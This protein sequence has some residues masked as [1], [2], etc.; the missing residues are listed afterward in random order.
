MSPTQPTI[1]LQVV[2]GLGNRIRAMVSGMALAEGI[3]AKL[4][5]YWFPYHP[6][7]IC[8]FDTIFDKK[9]L[10]SWMSISPMDLALTID[11]LNENDTYNML[12]K[13]D[14]K[15]DL[16]IKSYG[17][18]FRPSVVRWA[19]YLRALKPSPKIR[20]LVK[21]RIQ[22]LINPIGVHIRRGDNKKSIEESPTE[23]FVEVMK[24]YPPTQKFIVATDDLVVKSTLQDTF[25]NRCI[26][27]AKRISRT[28]EEGMREAAI[29]FFAIA[30]CSKILGSVYSSFSDIA[31]L[32]G[33]SELIQIKRS[34]SI[35]HLH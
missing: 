31:A 2:A 33:Q 14:E 5:V 15:S 11:T 1:H 9:S 25:P 10:P 34:Q 8:H 17:V 32:Y 29:D 27:P 18:F 7:C 23:A 3:H 4:I 28:N 20:E 24:T 21:D 35:A 16:Y 30:S 19:E 6:S 12:I 22:G 26:F 13:W